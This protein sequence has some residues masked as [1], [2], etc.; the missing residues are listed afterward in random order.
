MSVNYTHTFNEFGNGFPNDGDDVICD[1]NGFITLL[2]VISS[3][4]IHTA[5]TG[6]GDGNYVYLVC[7]PSPTSWDDL[8][9]GEQDDLY[10]NG[11][12]VAPVAD[13]TISP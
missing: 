5:Q 6:S 3:S 10:E 12:H 11:Y 13:L 8:D 1:D 2:T 4:P 7:E 9:D